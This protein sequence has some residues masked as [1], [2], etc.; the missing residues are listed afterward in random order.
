MPVNSVQ[1]TQLNLGFY[2]VGKK[3][4]GYDLLGPT[5]LTKDLLT[6]IEPV[7]IGPGGVLYLTNGHHTFTSLTKSIYGSANPTVY[8]NVIA[9]YSNLTAEQF[10]AQMQASNFLL[11]LDN[12]VIK[13]VDPLTGTPI[14]SSFAGMTNDPYRGLEYS[15]LKNKSSVLFP[16]ASNITGATGASTPGLDKTA[17]F[18]SDFI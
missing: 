7:V 12:G 8:V 6:S 17:A 15:I 10:W 3:I 2:E 9:N 4:T 13:S 18:Y 11:P 16:N 14:P 5:G 1:P